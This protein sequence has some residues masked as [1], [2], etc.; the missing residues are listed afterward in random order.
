MI[1]S[2]TGCIVE[3]LSEQAKMKRFACAVFMFA[4]RLSCTEQIG[5]RIKSIY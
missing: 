2:V 3:H 5:V 1:F 4:F